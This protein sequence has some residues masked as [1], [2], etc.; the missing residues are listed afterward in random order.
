M[1]ANAS[2]PTT[3]DTFQGTGQYNGDIFTNP[4]IFHD[5]RVGD[6]GETLS[7]IFSSII[8]I[9]QTTAWPFLKL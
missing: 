2:P 5:L 3:L 8:K 9:L 6:M 1:V 4:I 7:N